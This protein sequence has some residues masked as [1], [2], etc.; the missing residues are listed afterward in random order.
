MNKNV[1]ALAVAAAMAAPLAAQAEVKVSGGLQAQLVNYSGGAASPDGWY[2]T[3]G[4]Q[5]PSINGATGAL[6]KSKENSGNYGFLKFAASE[7]LGNG[8]KALAV[9]NMNI[10][11]G[12]ADGPGDNG[13]P[14]G[15][16]AYI[17]LSGNFGTVL[18]GTLSNP[19]KSATVKWDPFLATFAQARG[20]GGASGLHNSYVGNAVAYANKFGMAKVVAA[21]VLDETSNPDKVDDSGNPEKTTAQHAKALS[22]NMPVGPVEVALGYVDMTDFGGKNAD[23][24][25]LKIGV[26]YTAGAITASLQHETIGAGLGS[27]DDGDTHL[28]LSGSYAMGANTFS[29]SYGQQAIST[30]G[31]DDLDVTYTAIGVKHAF[32]KTV[33]ATVA[34]RATSPDTTADA[35]ESAF[36]AGLRVGF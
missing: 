21:V 32:S 17:G 25:A 20:N 13:G 34:Y 4:D 36:G 2:A 23:A 7:D 3:D 19:Y 27:S 12:D 35:D 6:K 22:V 1:I 8:M 14:G 10:S 5:Y 26:K 18:A 28:L 31:A 29:L 24:D 33:S 16:E 11:V 15:R 30:K 9:Y